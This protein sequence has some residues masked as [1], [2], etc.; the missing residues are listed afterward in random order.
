ME[1]TVDEE[2]YKRRQELIEA[3]PA[4]AK[5]RDLKFKHLFDSDFGAHVSIKGSLYEI[6]EFFNDWRSELEELM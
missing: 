2:D 1:R 4:E 5:A 3:L 6:V